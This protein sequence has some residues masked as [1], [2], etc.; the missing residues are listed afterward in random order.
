MS[1]KLTVDAL[2]QQAVDAGDVPGVVAIAADPERILYEGAFGKRVLG[3]PA[4]M[5][6]DTVGWIASM[7][8]AITSAAALQLVE[9]G[10]LDLH[11]PVS[12]WLPEIESIRVLEGFDASGRPRTRAP[13]R[14]VTLAHLLTHTSGFSYEFWNESILQYQKATETPGIVESRIASLRTPLMF[15]PG[16]RWAYGIGID[17]AGRAIEAVSGKRLGAILQENVLGPLGMS[18]TAFKISASMRDRLA[19]IHHRAADKKLVAGDVELPQDPEI[20]LGGAGLYGTMV[21]YL[22]FVQMILNR[23]KARGVQVLR[24]QSV[25][26]MSRNQT[27]PIRVG[28]LKSAMPLLS[29]DAEF[30]PGLEKHHTYGF[31]ITAER[32]PSGLPAG[33]LTWAGLANSFYWIDPSKKLAGVYLTQIL[34]FADAGAFTPFLEFQGALY[35]TLS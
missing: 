27:G 2:L 34:P 18:D 28:P 12:R 11:S 6:L 7:T 21:D 15:D 26:L 13:S 30:F 32:A 19:K 25:D 5:T 8:K 17:W 23:G 16:E 20:E 29:N 24:E 22:K 35:R 33:S 4:P 1:L 10:K 14:P 31:Q 3:Q 9:R